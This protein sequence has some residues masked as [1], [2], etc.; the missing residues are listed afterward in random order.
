LR[1]ELDILRLTLATVLMRSGRAV[2]IGGVLAAVAIALSVVY[3]AAAP[4]QSN[5]HVSLAKSVPIPGAGGRLDHM[6][7]DAA[8]QRVFLAAV[9]DGSLLVIGLGDGAV[10]R[11]GGYDQPHGVLFLASMGEVVLTTGNG[12]VYFLNSTTFQPVNEIKLSSDAD[13]VRYDQ[14]SGSMYVGYGEGASGG[15]AQ[16]DPRTGSVDRTVALGGHPESFQL[17]TSNGY[18]YANMPTLGV[19]DKVSLQGLTLEGN[20]STGAY[21]DN[22]PMAIDTTGGRVFV[23]AWFPSTL[24]SYSEPSGALVSHVSIAG[25]ADDIYYIPSADEALVS[26]GQGFVDLVS[27]RGGTSTVVSEVPSASGARTSLFLQQ[28]MQ[29][30]VAAPATAT[31]PANLLVFSVLA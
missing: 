25:D 21:V 19:V 17:D 26:C 11:H 12:T 15:I 9:Q 5:P 13:N 20:W 31:S 8:T 3:L 14:A 18:L 24:I 2:A 27:I 7:F 10:T 16:I 23:V 28:S 4:G 1:F 29:L 22:Y 6:D 30:L